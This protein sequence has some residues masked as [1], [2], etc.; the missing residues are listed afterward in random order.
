MSTG[1][2]GW[3]GRRRPNCTMG[4]YRTG[5][6][7]FTA[8]PSLLYKDAFFLDLLAASG[9]MLAMEVMLA[10]DREVAVRNYLFPGLVRSVSMALEGVQEARD[11]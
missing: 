11:G 6:V 10:D 7:Y 2:G 8:L 3:G 9:L 5:G 4:I 1:W